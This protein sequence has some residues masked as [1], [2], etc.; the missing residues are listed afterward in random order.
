MTNIWSNNKYIEL[1]IN[2]MLFLLGIN[3][4]HLG[5]LFLPLICLLLFIDRNFRFKVNNIKT[6]VV[7]CLFG[8][9]FF[10]FSYKLGVYA[11][12]G[13]TLPMAYYIGSNMNRSNKNNLK[14]V[15]YLLAFSMSTYLLINFAF[16][17]TQYPLQNLFA[18][19]RRYDI[20]T[21]QLVRP[22]LLSVHGYILI[23]TMYYLLRF[24]KNGLI[25]VIGTI[26]FINL[27]IYNVAMARRTIILFIILSLLLCLFLDIFFASN[28][29]LNNKTIFKFLI[30]LIAVIIIICSICYFN[31]FGIWDIVTS[32]GL[33]DKL[34]SY[35]FKS[36]RINY[37]IEGIKLVPYHLWGGQEIS[38]I[39]GIQIHD[40]WSDIYDYA[41]LIPWAL[42]VVYSLYC[43]KV[44]VNTIK[45]QVLSK[46]M[47]LLLINIFLIIAVSMMME[48]AFTST[49]VYVITAVILV[50]CI[51]CKIK[52]IEQ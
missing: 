16:E 1:T 8:I 39:I 31:V 17:L 24:E 3:F 26:L 29:R 25:K 9:S 14:Y 41:G 30:I 51:E 45:L 2:I 20:W 48:P 5:Q 34:V 50:A 13:F 32:T 6:F 49:S 40:L 18:K 23:G 35:G 42:I 28:I 12:M 27:L 4:M 7:L 33:Y 46:N 43:L 10:I 37:L 38:S 15:I 36:E 11:V 44:I 19:V 52:E 22:T 21:R 47:K